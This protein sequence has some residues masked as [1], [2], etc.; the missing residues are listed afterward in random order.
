FVVGLLTPD[1]PIEVEP[2]EAA[3]APPEPPTD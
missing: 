3:P 1:R 2:T